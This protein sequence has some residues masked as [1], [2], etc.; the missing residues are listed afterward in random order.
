MKNRLSI[1]SLLLLGLATASC[2]KSQETKTATMEETTAKTDSTATGNTEAE[3]VN[4]FD[5]KSLAGW[6]G[7]NKTGEVKNWTVIDGALVCLGAAKDAHGGDLVTDKQYSNFELTWDWKVDKGSNSGVMYHVVEDKK[8]QA[9]YETGP[10]YQVMDDIGFPQKLENW[11][12]AG[13]DY[14]MSPANDQKKLMPAGEWNSSKIVYNNGHLEH[15][16]N[17]EKIVESDT[18]SEAWKK[19]RA[20]GKWKDFPDY[21]RAQTGFIA[22]QDHGN[23]A[24]FKNIKIK[25]L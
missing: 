15:W 11:Q 16:L 2:N 19:Q 20:E 23:K 1:M 24:Y 18:N 12:Q 4:L 8:Y 25:E 7:F 22:L 10:E 3:W 6:H 17:G 9:P 14:A 13:A 21:A 5:G